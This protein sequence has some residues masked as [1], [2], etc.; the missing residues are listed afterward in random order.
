MSSCISDY[1][2]NIDDPQINRNN[3]IFSGDGLACMS[4]IRHICLSLLQKESSKPS[5]KKKN[6]LRYL[7]D[8]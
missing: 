5:I 1:F 2:F 6:L 7:K 4:I 3:F 8:K